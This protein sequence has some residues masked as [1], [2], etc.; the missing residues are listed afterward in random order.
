[1]ASI[2]RVMLMGNVTRDPEVKFTPKGTAVTDVGL[3]VNRQ[4]TNPSGEKV[5]ET[6]F[7][8]VEIWGRTAEVAGEYAKKGRPVLIEG[9][10]RM[11]TWED[12]ASGQKR[13]KLK[14]VCENL[15]LLGG[16]PGAGSPS[17][18]GEE[19]SAPSP[20]NSAPPPAHPEDDD[21]PF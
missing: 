1:M 5:E 19:G 9:R 8:D 17:R 3:A 6:V 16:K 4:Y 13:S 11:D 20:R 14:V 12:K 21:I 2:N 7:V 18:A 15:H 10:L